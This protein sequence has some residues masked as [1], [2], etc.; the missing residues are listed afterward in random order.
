MNY[1]HIGWQTFKILSV[2]VLVW[3]V[4]DLTYVFPKPCFW[5]PNYWGNENFNISRYSMIAVDPYMIATAV[6]IFS[7]T[8]LSFN[9]LAKKTGRGWRWTPKTGQCAKLWVTP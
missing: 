1:F 8:A 4:V 6:A 5:I 7:L 3:V 9:Y 2:L